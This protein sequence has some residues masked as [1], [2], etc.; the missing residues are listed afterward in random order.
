MRDS[1]SLSGPQARGLLCSPALEEWVCGRRCDRQQQVL[2][3]GCTECQGVVLT[4]QRNL[5]QSRFLPG[6]DHVPLFIDHEPKPDMDKTRTPWKPAQAAS[7]CTGATV[8]QLSSPHEL[9]ERAGGGGRV[10]EGESMLSSA[11]P[12]Q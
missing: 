12:W 8:T 4:G 2:C 7:A 6:S 11:L 9:R 10:G 3:V 1:A 5:D